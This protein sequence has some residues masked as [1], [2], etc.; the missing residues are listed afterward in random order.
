MSEA[1]ASCI[2]PVGAGDEP[3]L[4]DLMEEFYHHERLRFERGR[5]LE[6]VRTLR[7]DPRLGG[8]WLLEQA[9]RVVGYLVLTVCW[10]LE[11]AGRYALVDEL[12][13]REGERGRGLG[14]RAL[15]QAVEAC[16]ALGVA[17]LRLEVD[18]DNPRAIA[19]YRRMGF[20]LQERYQMS[21]WLA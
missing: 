4:L 21:R 6:G 5:A 12:Y 20:T 9:G 17:A 15:E 1:P 3:A 7:A 13:V 16:R 19:L 8:V 14:A 10:S 11:F 2:R 18:V